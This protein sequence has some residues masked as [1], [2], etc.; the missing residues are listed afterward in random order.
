MKQTNKQTN[1]QTYIFSSFTLIAYSISVAKIFL[2]R[3]EI[4]YLI[5]FIFFQ[6]IIYEK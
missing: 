3:L 4:L 5:N 6:G 1:K 2:T